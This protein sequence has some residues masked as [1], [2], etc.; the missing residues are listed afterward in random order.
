M[1]DFCDG[2]TETENKKK[3]KKKEKKKK[4]KNFFLAQLYQDNAANFKV[5]K[6]AT[7]LPPESHSVA[8]QE[9]KP[10]AKDPGTS[11]IFFVPIFCRMDS[12]SSPSL[13]WNR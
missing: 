12:L 4:K 8:G 3:K 7:T 11:L 1:N 5:R 9:R 6:S 13:I 10:K 2:K